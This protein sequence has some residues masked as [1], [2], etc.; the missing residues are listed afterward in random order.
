M[1]GLLKYGCGVP[2][3]RIETLQR[4]LGIP[5]PEATQWE[6]VRDAAPRLAPAWDELLRQA[7]QGEVLHNDDT[8]MKVLELTREQR[9]AAAADEETGERTGVFPSG[10]VAT[11]DGHRV[12]LFLHGPQPRRRRSR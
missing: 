2:F 7:A 12:A 9:R 11:R 4:G 5:L 3:N 6:L 8:T 10:I 1:V